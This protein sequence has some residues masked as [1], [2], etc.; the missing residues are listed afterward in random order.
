[1][2]YLEKFNDF[3][4]TNLNAKQREA[5]VTK[6]G[7]FL[8][9][10]GAGSGKTRVITARITNLVLHENVGPSSIVALTFTNKAAKE[11]QERVRSYLSADYQLPVVGTF[12]SYCL[13]LLKINSQLLPH[14]DFT[15]L[16]SDDQEQIIRNLLKKYAITKKIAPR[17][18]CAAISQFKND[19]TNLTVP[20]NP[21]NIGDPLIQ[22]L[23]T[24]Y[25]KEKTVAH[26]LDF[27]DLLLETLRLFQTQPL[28]KKR[29]QN[30]VRHVL[31]DEYQDTNK[32]QHALLKEMTL[33]DQRAC[34]VDSLCIVGDEDQSIY[35][36][37]GAT[38]SNIIDFRRDFPTTTTIT[39]DQNYRSVQPILEAANQVI[40]HNTERNP[41]NLWSDKPAQ[42]RI[43][44]LTCASQY[45]EG[46]LVALY[47]QQLKQKKQ[48]EKLAVL[49]RSHY[50]SRALEEALIRSSVPYKIIG[51]TQFYDRQEIKDVLAY[52][53]LAHNPFDRISFQ[54]AI[55]T[56]SRGLG[57]K[58]IEQFFA[59]WDPQPFLDFKGIAQLLIEKELTGTKR[60]SLKNFLSIFK[61]LE[62][63]NTAHD[64]AQAILMATNY[65]N[66]L[67]DAYEAEEASARIDNV[68]ELINGIKA[69][70]ERGITTLSAFLDEVALLQDHITKADTTD[71]FVRLM[72][73]H[74]A[75]GLEF[76]TVIIAGLEEGLLPSSHSLFQQESIEEE[77]RLLYVGIT[78]ARERLL[79]TV[80]KYRSTYGQITDQRP[81]RFVS[82]LPTNL[83]ARHDCS[84]WTTVQCSQHL[85]MSTGSTGLLQPTIA[86]FAQPKTATKAASVLATPSRTVPEHLAARRTTT[87][88]A[89]SKPKFAGKA[90]T[91]PIATVSTIV[92]AGPWKKH[93]PVVHAIFGTGIIEQID[94][95][96]TL[97][98]R[99][100]T[101]TKKIAANF[102]SPA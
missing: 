40:K 73:L 77:R 23:Y 6:N 28:F 32:V 48:L 51:G 61:G 58:F 98:I 20:P 65:F 49:Y 10:A 72:T 42:N 29:F 14:A 26:L 100:K 37:R 64:T 80:C 91:K 67:K 3:I 99:F 33:D 71:G 92:A 93:Q 101:G 82:E 60:D 21:H 30:Q 97:T 54:R 35:S 11:M 45:Q 50:Q 4:N 5:V 36:W 69:L 76:D 81:S 16:D 7:V 63:Y 96:N 18:V 79:L 56:P 68:K 1:M 39:I 84:Q 89:E 15:V 41:K 90:T 59:T 47:G 2:S 102:V 24:A 74:G 43:Q 53:R 46:A 86:N 19:T 8:V 22:Q 44:L 55:S 52:L 31:V 13:R 62:I 95:A 17:A 25:E 38:V 87:K 27:D 12:H 88:Y 85:A 9:C 83:V 78:R 66:Y 75:K 57:D 94:N 70:E 34:Q